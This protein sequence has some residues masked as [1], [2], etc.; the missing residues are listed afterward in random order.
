LK[1]TLHDFE[2]LSSQND[3]SIFSVPHQ[4][5]SDPLGSGLS[6]KTRTKSRLH[7]KIKFNE[8]K[9]TTTN[10]AIYIK[11]ILTL[12]SKLELKS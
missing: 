3:I 10:M 9:Q 4:M 1:I 6:P 7:H 2:G 11:V 5:I 8:T 12:R